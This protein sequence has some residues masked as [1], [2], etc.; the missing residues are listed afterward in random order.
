MIPESAKL[1]TL[2]LYVSVLSLPAHFGTGWIQP[3]SWKLHG[4]TEENVAYDK[5]FLEI[6]LDDHF[7]EFGFYRVSHVI[8]K[9]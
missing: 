3:S 5:G 6:S 1:P 8:L 7:C 4:F 9:S 2:T